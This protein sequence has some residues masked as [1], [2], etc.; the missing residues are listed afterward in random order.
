MKALWQW[1]S[2]GYLLLP[3]LG[4]S[5]FG[6]WYLRWALSTGHRED[7][8]L[9]KFLLFG[10]MTV[11]PIILWLVGNVLF[12]REK[13]R[14]RQGVL[15]RPKNPLNQ[16][17]KSRATMVRFKKHPG[18]VL[19][20]CLFG[21]IFGLAMICSSFFEFGE[22]RGLVGQGKNLGLIIGGIIC[23]LFYAGAVVMC[24]MLL[25]RNKWDSCFDLTIA[26]LD[27]E[28]KLLKEKSAD[29]DPS[30]SSG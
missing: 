28:I 6:L 14:L 7:L 26:R 8:R 25:W 16:K 17:I 5:G 11:V 23:S 12:P 21:L 27:A 19:S 18:F 22:V 20:F 1:I 13:K 15:R 29:A 9:A 2:A 30:T 4:C 10:G 3:S 24:A